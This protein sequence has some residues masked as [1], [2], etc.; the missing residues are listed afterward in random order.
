MGN[1]SNTTELVN[2][3]IGLL[4][5]ARKRL[6]SGVY[7]ECCE[8]CKESVVMAFRGLL[9]TYKFNLNTKEYE[10]IWLVR[11]CKQSNKRLVRRIDM[12]EVYNINNIG[13]LGNREYNKE[14]AIEIYGY[15]CEL[16]SMCNERLGSKY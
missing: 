13:L 11:M 12:K 6:D 3:S 7:V 1:E 16:V 10:L 8:I 2:E 5:K 15:A 9:S 4:I 14:E